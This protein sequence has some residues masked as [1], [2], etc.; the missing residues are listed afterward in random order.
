LERVFAVEGVDFDGEE[1]V[2]GGPAGLADCAL[3]DGGYELGGCV[4]DAAEDLVRG[5]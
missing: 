4:C 3:A 2:V 5:V 1:V